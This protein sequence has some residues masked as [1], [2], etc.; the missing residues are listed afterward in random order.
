MS[1]RFN[2]FVK[3]SKEAHP[4]LPLLHTC[5]S[6][7]FRDIAEE[8]RLIPSR[9]DVFEE[10]LLYFFYG[11]PAYRPAKGSRSVSLPAFLPITIAID[12]K[13]VEEPCRITPFDTGAFSASMFADHLHP[14]MSLGDFCLDTTM[15]MPA[16]AVSRFFGSNRAYYEGKPRA[17]EIP[18]V[19]FEAA[20][21]YSLV[22]NNA[23]T[24]YDDRRST[25]E[26][27]GDQVV[28]LSDKNVLLV[29]LP[30]VFLDVPTIRETLVSDW[31]AEI[32]TYSFVHCNPREYMAKIYDEVRSFFEVEG[33]F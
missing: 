21:Y 3:I 17:V 11:R 10:T 8:G 18:I 28:R 4:R 13:A 2:R 1:G 19:E 14:R 32:R 30:R 29:V 12:W 16:R 33:L 5:D 6:F 24:D 22:A 20:S 7:E 26:I 9:C 15:D 25:V 27:Q 31:C 23:R